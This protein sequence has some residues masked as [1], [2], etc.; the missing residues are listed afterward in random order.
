MVAIEL[1]TR[2]SSEVPTTVE[3]VFEPRFIS[4]KGVPVMDDLRIWRFMLCINFSILVLPKPEAQKNPAIWRAL[5][6]FPC[7]GYKTL[8]GVLSSRASTVA[9]KEKSMS[10]RKAFTFV[11]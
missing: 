6:V 1:F 7:I 9:T 5:A 10:S 2:S 11:A 3:Y 4:P 8:S